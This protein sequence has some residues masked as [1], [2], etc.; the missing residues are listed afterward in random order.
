M[1]KATGFKN[2]WRHAEL[3]TSTGFDS[4]DEVRFY[5]EIFDSEEEPSP[6]PTPIMTSETDSFII[7]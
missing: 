4:G 5:V 3:F 6:D 7:G 1:F 2:L